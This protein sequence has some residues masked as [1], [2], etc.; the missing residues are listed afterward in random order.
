MEVIA[1]NYVGGLTGQNYGK[2]SKSAST[3]KVKGKSYIGGLIGNAYHGTVENVYSTGE[4]ICDNYGGGLI[5]WNDNTTITNTYTISKV[6]GSGSS[7]GGF[8]GSMTG[9]AVKNC[10]WSPE[11]SGVETSTTGTK[12]ATDALMQ[13]QA[14][15]FGFD[16]TSENPVWIMK[17]YP[18]LNYN[19]GGK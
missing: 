10:Y 8:M 13:T 2:I 18:E 16:F 1:T 6:T 17:T 5:G 14:T 3:G 9:P 12:V 15:Y 4:V 7:V 11:T 19:F